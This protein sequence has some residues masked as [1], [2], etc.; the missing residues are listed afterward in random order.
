M[1]LFTFLNK[2]SSRCRFKTV[3][4]GILIGD[5]CGSPYEGRMVTGNAIGP[6]TDDTEQALGIANWLASGDHSLKKLKTELQGVFSGPQRGYGA[7]QADF[8]QGKPTRKDSFGNGAAMRVACI[9]CYGK[10]TAQVIKLA[11]LQCQLT[12]KH[13]EAV[14]GAVTI[15]LAV[16][17]AKQGKSLD[18]LPKLYLQALMPEAGRKYNCSLQAVES[19]P[20]AIQ[21]VIDGK[22]FE[23]TL[24][25]ALANGN[26]TDTIAAMAC[27]IAAMKYGIPK[28]RPQKVLA[29]HKDNQNLYRLICH[30]R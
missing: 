3:L 13:P 24:S 4:T 18:S 28:Q 11:T 14:A 20:P 25:K 6:Y 7:G 30:Y 15:A 29:A 23:S 16:F 17:L 12:H 2:F 22:N 21:A 5:A 9:G 8:L 19:V 10:D 1:T 26:D 27:A